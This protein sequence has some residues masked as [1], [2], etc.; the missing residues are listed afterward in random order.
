MTL[1]WAANNNPPWTTYVVV[2]S[3]SENFY[4][5]T[6]STEVVSLSHTFEG[7]QKHKIYYFYVRAKNLDGFLS[8]TLYL[9]AV[10]IGTKQTIPTLSEY[11]V[12]SSLAVDNEGNLHISYVDAIS[13][14]LKYAKW[15]PSSG[16]ST[17]MTVDSE[18]TAYQTCIAID[19]NNRP[20]ISYYSYVS[21][22]LKYAYFD[23]IKWSTSTVDNNVYAIH[24]SITVGSSGIPEILYY[25]GNFRDLKYAYREGNS[26]SVYTIDSSGDIGSYCSIALDK[27]GKPH[28]SYVDATNNKL[29]YAYRTGS[30]IT[31]LDVD[32]GDVRYT[33]MVIDKNDKP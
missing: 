8:D 27:Q 32:T 20:H 12:N 17:P 3:T 14:G 19:G 11:P 6:A 15:T 25:D 18:S 22:K 16:W 29:K 10:I 7:L 4:P 31:S 9:P 5:T 21:S 24:N 1:R 30:D 28:F 13:N 26:W 33:S 23:G 2:C